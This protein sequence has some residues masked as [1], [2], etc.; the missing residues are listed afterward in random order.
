MK[1]NATLSL[2]FV[3]T[4]SLNAFC[5]GNNCQED[6][7]VAL[8]ALYLSTDG[9]NWNNNTNWL[10]AAEFTANPTM[11][12]GT[13]VDIWHGVTLD[14]N[15]CVN[16]LYLEFNNL[17]GPLPPEIDNLINLTFLSL[18]FNQL[19]GPI[20][21]ELGNLNLITLGL[22]DNQL[23]GCYDT[24]LTSLCTQLNSNFNNNGSI[25]NGNNFDAPWED[26]CAA[27][28]GACVETCPLDI[29]VN[30]IP[31]PDSLYQ[32]QQTITS[33]GQVASGSDVTFKAGD[34]I[35]LDTSFTVFSGGNLTIQIED[36]Q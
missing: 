22:S 7:Y 19:T 14:G 16:G 2:L 36:C 25:S 28:A 1:I 24:N 13:D 34:C 4:I 3:F 9:D 32:A 18:N 11:P 21:P 5:Q 12:A 17:S 35:M 26:F 10:T 33:S 8:R 20:P 27:G 6:D 15:G 31:I 30:D 29:T 23:S